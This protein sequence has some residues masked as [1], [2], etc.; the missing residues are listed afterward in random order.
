VWLLTVEQT[1]QEA[2]E[3]MKKIE[4]AAEE[5]FVSESNVFLLSSL[6]SLTNS[7]TDRLK[8]FGES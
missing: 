1:E 3:M 6:F 5:G 8:G 4:K 2:E 7:D